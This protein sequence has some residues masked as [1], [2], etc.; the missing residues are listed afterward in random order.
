MIATASFVFV[1]LHKSG[2]TFVNEC[3]LRFVPGARRIGYHLP[4]NLIPADSATLP[5]LG[6]VRNPWSYYVSWYAF[7]S[8]MAQPNA[9]FRCMS[10]NRTLDFKG[11]IRNLLALGSDDGKLDEVLRA[12]PV[13]Y[14][15]QGL[16]L[17]AFAL[18][19]IRGTGEGFYSYLYRYMY[20]AATALTIG[21]VETLRADLAS[22]LATMRVP[23]SAALRDFI[24]HAAPHNTSQHADA[25]SY[26]DDELAALVRERDRDV[27]DAYDYRLR[28]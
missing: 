14:G 28:G 1:H 23:M 15:N 3:L 17:P 2:G 9:L 21:R 4:A 12:L 7:Q 27:V 20:G 6:F 8:Q 22:F 24:T 16:N 25:A 11:T 5:V 18:A 13:Q 19:P 10:A 26:F